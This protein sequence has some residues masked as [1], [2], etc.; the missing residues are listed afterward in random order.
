L[1]GVEV[2]AD[3]RG[4]GLGAAVTMGA[5]RWAAAR[6]ARHCYLQVQSDNPARNRYERWGFAA[7]H[8]YEHWLR[9]DR[10]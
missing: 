10:R 3:R 8:E 1:F 5:L 7:H 2:R 9:E 4:Q 6:G